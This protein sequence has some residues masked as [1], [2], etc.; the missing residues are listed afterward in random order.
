LISWAVELSKEWDRERRRAPRNARAARPPA[1][2]RRTRL[3][4]LKEWIKNGQVMAIEIS[5]AE[6]NAR[7]RGRLLTD[8]EDVRKAVIHWALAYQACN[9]PAGDGR[10]RA[11]R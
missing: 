3:D 7:Y 8:A 6:L 4:E 1:G 5:A 11:S 10:V 2:R 9:V